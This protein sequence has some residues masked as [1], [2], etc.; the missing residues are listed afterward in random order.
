MVVPLFL[1]SKIHSEFFL[2]LTKNFDLTK[3]SSKCGLDSPGNLFW[4]LGQYGL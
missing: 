2:A 1:G 4:N 3:K